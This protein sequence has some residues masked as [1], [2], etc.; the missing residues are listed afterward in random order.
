[1]INVLVVDDS[2]SAREFIRYVL[3]ADPEIEVIGTAG[4][5]LAALE[6]VERLCPDVVTMDINM[7]KLNGLEATRRIMETC[8]T[9]II[10]VSGNLDPDEVATSF[11]A[12][13]AGAL[14]ALP[15]PRAI[16]HPEHARDIQ[17]L[18]QTVKLMAEVKVVRRWPRHPKEPVR[19]AVATP[20]P[21]TI[22]TPARVIA[23][24]ASTGGPIVLQTILSHLPRNFPA[25][26]LVVQHMAAGFTSGFAE[27]LAL[28][29]PLPVQLARPGM[30]P[31]P[32]QVYLAPDG[33]H[34]QVDL[35]GRL[36]LSDASPENGLRPAVSALFRSVAQV[37]GKRAVAVLLTGM[38]CDGAQE[39]KQLKAL[40]ATTIVQDRESSIV[41]GMPGEAVRLGAATFELPPDKIAAALVTLTDHA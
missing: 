41:F 35:A 2:S 16:S 13:E 38:G 20:I 24:G 12:M 18:V 3:A 27:W 17:T 40:G 11:R 15:K 10:I 36:V 9:P 37:F 14:V 39:L 32:G 34:L 6:A 28:T 33:F 8:P 31:S 1:M 4:D 30:A 23:I 25:P 21:A 7:P 5:G 29:S 22:S 19:T 26:L